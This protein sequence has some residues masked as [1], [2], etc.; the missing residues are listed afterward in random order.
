M[1]HNLGLFFSLAKNKIG[2]KGVRV[3]M[4]EREEGNAWRRPG[5]IA[6]GI[7]RSANELQSLR[8]VSKEKKKKRS[9]QKMH[10]F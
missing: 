7:W 10:E 4:E 6:I 8:A 3:L 1:K 9:G 2:D 5:G